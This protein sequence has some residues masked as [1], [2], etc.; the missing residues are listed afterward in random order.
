MFVYFNINITISIEYYKYNIIL[1]DIAILY[2]YLVLLYYIFIYVCISY[3][4]FGMFFVFF[5]F[6]KSPNVT[7]LSNFSLVSRRSVV[8]KIKFHRSLHDFT[9]ELISRFEEE[10]PRDNVKKKKKKIAKNTEDRASSF[11][12]VYKH[13]RTRVCVWCVIPIDV[14]CNL[15]FRN[16]S[17]LTSSSVEYFTCTRVSVWFNIISIDANFTRMS[18]CLEEFHHFTYLLSRAVLSVHL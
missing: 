11:V 17:K 10:A 6:R 12:T 13:G 16:G 3:T 18:P 7:D 9:R 4:C 8:S 1:W 14:E 2:W 15:A 5:F